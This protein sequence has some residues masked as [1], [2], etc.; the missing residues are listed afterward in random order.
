MLNFVCPYCHNDLKQSCDC[1]SCGLSFPYR[2]GVYHFYNPGADHWQASFSEAA[3]EKTV[4]ETVNFYRCIPGTPYIF[5][6]KTD[7]EDL[8][9]L[10][11]NALLFN[12]AFDLLHP[13]LINKGKGYILDVATFSGWSAY[14]LARYKPTIALD[15][16]VQAIESIYADFGKGIVKIVGDGQYLPLPDNSID[17]IFMNSGYHHM[18]DR[19]RALNEWWR[20]LKPGGCLVATGETP[21]YVET[22][23]GNEGLLAQGERGYTHKEM[24]ETFAQCKFENIRRLAV[25]YSDMMQYKGMEARLEGGGGDNGIIVAIK[26]DFPC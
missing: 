17:A 5:V 9:S 16:S 18:I 14:L 3:K 21:A 19:L 13:H 23:V 10:R 20:V 6:E 11:A 22:I 1:V 4:G 24:M 8:L 2:N 25:Q 12:I 7:Q 15:V 26:E